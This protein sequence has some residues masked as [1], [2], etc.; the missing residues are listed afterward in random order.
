MQSV[1]NIFLIVMAVLAVIVFLALYRVDAGYGKF[2]QPKWGPSL[3][4][5]VGWFLMEVP[6]FIAML[7]LWWFSPMR[8]DM[9]R[10]VF[11]LIFE[12]HYF[13]RA[14]ACFPQQNALGDCPDGRAFQYS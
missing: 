2:Y 1:F 11:L 6:V 14:E 9:V 7:V 4:N 13:N 12:C 8:T 3:D 5:H 10:I